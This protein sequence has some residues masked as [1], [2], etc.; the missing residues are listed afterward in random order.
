MKK[1]FYRWLAPEAEENEKFRTWPLDTEQEQPS[2]VTD[3]SYCFTSIARHVD[4]WAEDEIISP[5]EELYFDSHR[6]TANY[7]RI[8]DIWK[9]RVIADSQDF[10][11]ARLSDEQYQHN[12]RIVKIWKQKIDK[13]LWDEIQEGASFEWYFGK[14]YTPVVEEYQKISFK[15]RLNLDSDDM[16]M[17]VREL[18]KGFED[19]FSDS[20]EDETERQ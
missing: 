8:D 4:W 10:F 6:A 17:M 12:D 19:I 14:K 11:V 9:G 15:P 7:V 20:E 3:S 2:S 13:S 16:E 1:K 5:I 18:I